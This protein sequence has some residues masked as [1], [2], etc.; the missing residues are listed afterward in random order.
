MSLRRLP[1]EVVSIVTKSLDLE[2][3]FHLA[4][5]CQ[6]FQYLIRDDRSCKGFLEVSTLLR[7]YMTLK[8]SN[9]RTHPLINT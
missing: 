7:I 3:I 9:T 4:L 5:S 1:Y 6:R 8:F 2:D